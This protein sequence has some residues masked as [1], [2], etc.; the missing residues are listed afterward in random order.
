MILRIVILGILF[1]S[2]AVILCKLLQFP[3]LINGILAGGIVALANIL[4]IIYLIKKITL[5]KTKHQSLMIMVFLGKFMVLGLILY[6]LIARFHL[7]GLGIIIGLTLMLFS[8]TIAGLSP[9][10]NALREL[11]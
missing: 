10:L 8:V 6:L 3:Y 1:N 5:T 9:G 11:K 2:A 7:N 4:V